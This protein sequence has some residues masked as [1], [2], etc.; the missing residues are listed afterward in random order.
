MLLYLRLDLRGEVG[1][2]SRIRTPISLTLCY[3]RPPL[4]L[5][6]RA[7]RQRLPFSCTDVSVVSYIPV[8]TTIS[9]SGIV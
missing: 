9:F 1:F 4:A 2:T 7:Q 8:S 5:Y 3:I 6:L